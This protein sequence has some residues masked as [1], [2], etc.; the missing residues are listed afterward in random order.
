MGKI[1]VLLPLN[2]PQKDKFRQ[3]EKDHSLTFMDWTP[4]PPLET[5]KDAEIIVGNIPGGMLK[6][7]GHLRFYQLFSTGAN[8]Y[9]KDGIL[10]EGVVMACATG[11][12][13]LAI[14]EHMLACI[15]AMQ[16]NLYKYYDNQLAREWKRGG[17]AASVYGA[18]ALIIGA[19]DIGGEF[20][21]RLKLLGAYTVGVRR[22]PG[23]KPEYFDEMYTNDALDSLIPQ[24]DIISLSL[25]STPATVRILDRR[26]LELVKKGAYLVNVGRGD[27]IDTDAL[28]DCA[29]KFG[30]IS[31]DVTDPEPLPP[32][33]PLWKLENVYITPHISGGFSLP[34]TLDKIVDLAARNISAFLKGESIT[35]LVDPETGY[36]KNVNTA[37]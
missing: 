37:V 22:T 11:C 1:V 28:C 16:K 30:G 32:E 21:K 8:D 19:G 36:R 17:H 3:F 18:R 25:P 12:Y 5:V 23:K 15:L 35:S 26:R 14:S 4:Q 29:G 13:G 10:P 9:V 2:E 34:A 6:E 33:H 27:A 20:A 7:C 24:S 31:L